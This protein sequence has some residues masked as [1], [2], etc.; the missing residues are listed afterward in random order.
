M[1]KQKI[2]A[3][4]GSKYLVISFNQPLTENTEVYPGDPKPKKETFTDIKET[5]FHH[6]VWKISDHHFHPHGD[7][8]NHQNLEG[9]SF[10]RF[11]L[12]YF[13]NSACLIDLSDHPD[14][15]ERNGVKYIIEIRVEHLT[16]FSETISKKSAI[17]IRTGYDQWLELNKKH[18][19][20][21]IPYLT[22]EAGEF[23]AKFPNIKVFGIDSLT[24]DKMG[25][26]TVHKLFKDKLIVES[27][28]NL[29]SVPK[30]NRTN[31]DLQTST[32]A[33]AGATGG[34]V[35]AFAFVK[36]DQETAIEKKSSWPVKSAEPGSEKS[37]KPSI[38]N[39]DWL[40][41]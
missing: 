8:P 3:L 21:K 17:I 39:E 22:K 4:G 6:Y 11:D 32:I 24:V 2:V 13:F 5:G 15:E 10:E 31:F 14:A 40:G 19:P 27:L 26:H 12:D 23:L 25:E 33:I 35:S 29:Y 30:E 1:K 41:T 28:V 36:T 37:N 34:P 7:A 38:F 20:D 9:E 16:P 18:S